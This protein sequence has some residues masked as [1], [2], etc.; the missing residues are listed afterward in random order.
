M[1]EQGV[2]NG[3]QVRGAQGD[4]GQQQE[5]GAQGDGGPQQGG[6]PTGH[7]ITSNVVRRNVEM[8]MSMLFLTSSAALSDIRVHRAGSQLKIIETRNHTTLAT[9]F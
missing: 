7:I 8:S 4:G 6:G 5:G 2:G 1:S 3:V 9:I